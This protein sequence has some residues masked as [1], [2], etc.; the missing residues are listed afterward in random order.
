MTTLTD[1]RQTNARVIMMITVDQRDLI[2]EVAREGV[3]E[4]TDEIAVGEALVTTATEAIPQTDVTPDRSPH[5]RKPGPQPSPSG[6]STTCQSRAVAVEEVG[7][8]GIM[9]MTTMGATTITEKGC[10]RDYFMLK[11]R[12]FYFHQA[13]VYHSSCQEKLDISSLYQTI[14]CEH[15]MHH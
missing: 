5:G 15:M 9:G 13:T 3:E 4:A 2:M 14:C 11:T 12:I 1:S 10:G 7:V 6:S 8:R